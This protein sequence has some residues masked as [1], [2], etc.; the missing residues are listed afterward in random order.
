[1]LSRC[2]ENSC[3]VALNEAYI[4]TRPDSWVT[5]SKSLTI[6]II[7]SFY[8]TYSFS[9]F[10]HEFTMTLKAFFTKFRNECLQ[11]LKSKQPSVCFFSVWRIQT[12]CNLCS[13]L[14]HWNFSRYRFTQLH[15]Y[16]TCYVLCACR[17][18]GFC[19]LAVTSFF[20][21]K[22][23]RQFEILSPCL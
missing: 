23:K 4:C 1:M 13:S 16:S 3:T 14:Y 11:F 12:S 2:N 6:K 18:T 15:S 8:S 9:P 7:L 20:A 19:L 21:M 10:W 5:Q 17:E 22:M